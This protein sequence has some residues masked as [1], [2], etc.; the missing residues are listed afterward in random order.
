LCGSAIERG[1]G[2]GGPPANGIWPTGIHNEIINEAFPGLSAQQLQVLRQA[3]YDTDFTNRV[4][5]HDPQDPE[6]S[7]VHGMSDGTHNQDRMQA[8]QEGDAFIAQNEQ[9]AQEIQADWVASG[10]TGIAPAALTAFGNA[11]HTIEDRTSPAHAGNQPWYGTWTLS[12]VRHYRQ[13]RT[14]NRDQLNAS[15]AA[16]RAAFINTFGNNL[17]LLALQQQRACVTIQGVRGPV[18]QCN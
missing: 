18:T 5:G 9:N 11:L 14:I 3:S 2:E 10:H 16:A 8:Q 15:V 4:N 6:V 7:F 17:A 13:E 1:S 12:A